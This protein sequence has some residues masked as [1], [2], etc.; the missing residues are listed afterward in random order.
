MT[1]HQRTRSLSRSTALLLRESDAATAV[2]RLL[3][4]EQAKGALAFRLGCSLDEAYDH[5]VRVA[6]EG[7][8]VAAAR[9]AVA[10]AQRGGGRPA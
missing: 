4:V 8:V 3:A 9:P 2:S 6:G 7:S 10:E 5:L 1:Q